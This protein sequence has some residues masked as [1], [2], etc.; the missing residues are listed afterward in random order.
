MDKPQMLLLALTITIWIGRVHNPYGDVI[1]K[2]TQFRLYFMKCLLFLL[3]AARISPPAQK[4]SDQALQTVAAFFGL[5]VL[6]GVILFEN[7]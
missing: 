2:I 6:V 7:G 1:E 4:Y 5:E 3:L